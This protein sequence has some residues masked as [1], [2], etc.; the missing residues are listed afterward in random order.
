MPDESITSVQRCRPSRAK[1]Y[2]IPRRCATC[3]ETKAPAAFMRADVRPSGRARVCADCAKAW[4]RTPA[5]IARKA[6]YYANHPDRVRRAI[7][8]YT[9][10]HADEYRIVSRAGETL[11]RAERLGQVVRPSSCEQCGAGDR[12][13][14]AAHHDYN[15]PLN[16]RWLCKPCHG[17]WDR[18]EPKIMGRLP[19][20]A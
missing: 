3:G 15:E 10:K 6:A 18:A 16:V 1:D 20:T 17:R 4:K 19:R 7:E 14:E 8:A 9:A 11:R 2:S 5:E 13:I 12:R